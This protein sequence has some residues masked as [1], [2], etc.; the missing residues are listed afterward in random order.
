MRFFFGLACCAGFF[1][2][3]QAGERFA[4]EDALQP[5]T[6]VS[7]RISPDGKHLAAIGLA[8]DTSAV[9]VLD[10][11]TLAAQ[12]LPTPWTNSPRQV[13]WVNDTTLVVQT[14]Y[15]ANLVSRGGK[16]LHEVG[17]RYL[18]NTRRGPGGPEAILVGSFRSGYHID[19]VDVRTGKT[20]LM[21]FDMPGE[22][23][24]WVFDRAGVPRVATTVSTAFW[25]DATT[26]TH[27]YRA[28]LDHDWEKLATFPIT[29]DYWVPAYLSFD[30]KSLA[31]WSRH[32]RDTLAIFRFDLATRR[33]E[34]MMAGHATQDLLVV[35]PDEEEFFEYVV[36]GGMKPEAHWFESRWAM[37]Q[38]SIDAALPGR[39]NRLSGDPG[40]RI[41]VHSYSDVD[42]GQWFL[43]ETKN[44]VLKPV[45][46][47]RPDVDPARMRPMKIVSYRSFDGLE[48]PAYLTLPDDQPG[49][50]P[51]VL[52]IHGGPIARDHWRWNAQVQLL[53]AR[54]YAV[55]QPQFRGSAGFGRRFM[56]AGFGQWG[57]AMQDDLT[58]GARW[59][60]GQGVADPQRIC[61]YGASYGGYAALWGAAKTPGLY[62]CAI[63]FAGVS[64]LELMLKDDSDTNRVPYLRLLQREHV[65]DVKLH[66]QKFEEVS[67]LRQAA[68]IQAPVLIAHGE[69]DARVPIEHGKKMIAALKRHDKQ[70]EWLEFDDEGHG[71]YE[72]KNRERYYRAVLD[73]L[74][75]HIGSSAPS[76]AQAAAGAK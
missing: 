9:I 44:M 22:P 47:S 63:S 13:A 57:L 6:I 30:E 56:R 69:R 33:I 20:E 15:S 68:R 18:G 42:P 58:A 1:A 36:T 62:R 48:I 76:S 46:R 37:L 14:A 60:I 35:Q 12:L 23:I 50:K 29:D 24:R 53:A 5:P 61:I 51:T 21:N 34:E 54:G 52:L 41:L 74:D 3:V 71:L 25:S 2:P 19:R 66:K 73:F 11:E 55:L 7:M 75:R 26:I 8:K 72:K 16:R 10:A 49:P 70:V 27:W 43:L 59:L 67:P 4:V 17:T 32:E 65:G 31:V 38:R 64:D 45:A 39:I 28:S 40:N